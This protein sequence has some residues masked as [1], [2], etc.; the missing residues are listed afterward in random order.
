MADEERAGREDATA[1]VVKLQNII[2]SVRD[3]MVEAQLASD[4]YVPT[5]GRTLL[6]VNQSV[7]I[8]RMHDAG[9]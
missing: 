2:T 3:G 6:N 4:E 5:F 7:Q 8:A 1:A 9:K